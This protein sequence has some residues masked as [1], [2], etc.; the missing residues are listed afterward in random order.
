MP[1]KNK[2]IYFG[3]E[4]NALE[5]LDFAQQIEILRLLLDAKREIVGIK[6]VNTQ[7]EYNDFAA[8][9][10]KGKMAYC[11]MVARASEGKLRKSTLVNHNCDGGT[12]AL[13]LEASTPKIESG[14]E[15][16]SYNLYETKAAARRL[17]SAIKG[18]SYSESETYGVVTG[19]A[20]E[21]TQAP[22]LVVLIVNSYQAMRVVQGYEYKTGKKPKLD[23]GAMQGM[24]SELTAYPLLS[25]EIN[26]SVFCP[27]TRMLCKWSDDEMGVAIPF[28]WVTAVTEGVL[29]TAGTTDSPKKKEEM[30]K[31]FAA[32]G[33][34]DILEPWIGAE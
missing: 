5:N 9:E 32:K 19:P 25:G 27:S 12:T 17:R 14:D 4:K 1:Y 8:Q 29:G 24:C 16:F 30:R 6:L 7:Q 28:E 34:G 13:G 15:Y 23:L 21:Y 3:Q 33:K 11:Q 10:C 2:N 31:R 20:Q 26:V 22:D 18:I